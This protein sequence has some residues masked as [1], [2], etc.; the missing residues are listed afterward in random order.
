MRILLIL[1][2]DAG[3]QAGAVPEYE[4]LIE[5]YYLFSDAG[6]EVVLAAE[7]G[8]SATES[9]RSVLDV[10]APPAIRRFT[11]DRRAREV[12]NDLVDLATVCADDFD[13]A[14]CLDS[15]TFGQQPSVKGHADSLIGKLLAATKPVAVISTRPTSAEA[16]NGL[17][18][19]GHTAK[20]SLLAARALLGAVGVR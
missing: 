4:G 2:T 16:K 8:G 9:D 7:G 10:D 17:L 3:S 12:M 14:L 18:V 1:N 5:A 20:A 6:M 13:A 19:I 15:R 11:A